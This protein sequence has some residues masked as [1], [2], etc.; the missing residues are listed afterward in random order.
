MKSHA[1]SP[2]VE[3]LGGTLLKIYF[4]TRDALNRSSIGCLELDIRAPQK[5]LNLSEKPI[6]SPGKLG[7]FD[8]SGTAMGWLTVVEGKRFL[9]YSGWNLGVT[10]PWRNTI[11]L[12][13]AGLGQNEFQKYSRAPLLD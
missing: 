13:T 6:L 10:V 2:A 11:G 5:I 7:L 4:T 8:D 9:Y 12:A 1:S 3:L